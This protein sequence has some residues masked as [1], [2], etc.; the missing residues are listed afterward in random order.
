MILIPLPSIVAGLRAADA[1]AEAQESPEAEAAAARAGLA[2]AAALLDG[3]E[4]AEQAEAEEEAEA[5]EEAVAPP[6]SKP[7][8]RRSAPRRAPPAQAQR[9]A[10]GACWNDDRD[11]LLATLWLMPGLPMP[12]LMR[13]LN[14][15]PGAEIRNDPRVYARAK[16]L[17]LGKRG[18]VVAAETAPAPVLAEQEA[19]IRAEIA[20]LLAALLVRA[21]ADE[22]GLS[23]QEVQGHIAALERVAA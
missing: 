10:P 23:L 9:A 19:E 12:D 1:V 8:A 11:Q 20:T 15:L 16:E 3:S 18:V 7:P 5:Q 17:N 2:M 21:I 14:A 22:T 4:P 6:P 13:K